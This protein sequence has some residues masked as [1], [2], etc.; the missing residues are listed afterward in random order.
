[1]SKHRVRALLFLGG[2]LG[3]S[4]D[5]SPDPAPPPQGD[6]ALG[7]D[8]I[9]PDFTFQTTR[10]LAVEIASEAGGGEATATA[11]RLRLEVRSATLGVIYRGSILAGATFRFDYPLPA[12]ITELEL[13]TVDDSG[14]ET[15]R[16]VKLDPQTPGLSVVVGGGS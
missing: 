13:V 5:P 6:S 12:D 15:V 11:Q 2:L 7:N 8:P 1:M 10:P 4:A 9:P 3:C 16:T 14:L